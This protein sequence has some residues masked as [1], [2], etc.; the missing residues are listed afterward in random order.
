[1]SD[2]VDPKYKFYL[3]DLGNL[4]KELAL[5]AKEI[6]DAE[7]RESEDY[8]FESGR[9]LAF[10][11]VISLMQQQ[12]RGFEIPLEELDLHDVNPDHDLV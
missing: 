6:A 2:P 1:M 12:A 10:H 7:Q 11:E 5:K 3:R 8:L 4:L 9:L